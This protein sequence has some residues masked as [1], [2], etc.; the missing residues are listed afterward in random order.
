[1]PQSFQSDSEDL[2]STLLT[3]LSST[4]GRLERL[5]GQQHPAPDIMPLLITLHRQLGQSNQASMPRNRPTSPWWVIL[6][7]LMGP[8][9]LLVTLTILRP[10]WYLPPTA[11][12]YQLGQQCEQLLLR[13][14]P[15]DRR[16]LVSLL[17]DP[18]PLP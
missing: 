3:E 18:G 9:L 6:P 1:M 13:L 8:L 4:L 12:T 17:E 7:A 2:T 10:T 16:R 5:A 15:E 14:P 11:R